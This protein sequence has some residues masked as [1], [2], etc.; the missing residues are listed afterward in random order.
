MTC[1]IKSDVMRIAAS[2]ARCSTR[3]TRTAITEADTTFIDYRA[4][5]CASTTTLAFVSFHGIASNG[6][7]SLSGASIKY[8]AFIV[9]IGIERRKGV[10]ERALTI[11]IK[12]LRLCDETAVFL[13]R[14]FNLGINGARIPWMD[15]RVDTRIINI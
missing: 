2:G 3:C 5:V 12:A 10:V 8:T 14:G 6:F 9:E 1:P 7:V 4:N 11:G 13:C 15:Q